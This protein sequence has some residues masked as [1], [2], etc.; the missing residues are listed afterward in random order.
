[1]TEQTEQTTTDNALRA[2]IMRR[3]RKY[4]PGTRVARMAEDNRRRQMTRGRL[5]RF[6][7]EMFP[8][9]YRAL[10]RSV[11]AEVDAERGAMPGD[12]S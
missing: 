9:E 6:F 2:E 8:D 5:L 12:E 10:Y 7:R 4:A 3:P 1:M 11:R